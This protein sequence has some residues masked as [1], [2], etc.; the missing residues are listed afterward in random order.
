MYR[1]SIGNVSGMYRGCIGDVSGSSGPI[2]GLLRCIL[3]VSA[4]ADE[5]M[6]GVFGVCRGTLGYV[7]RVLAGSMLI[8]TVL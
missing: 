8:S 5:F 6:G 2:G 3:Y 7:S 1:G 4:A